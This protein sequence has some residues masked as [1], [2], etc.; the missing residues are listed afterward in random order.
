MRD[1]K[2]RA[3]DEQQ[4][5]MHKVDDIKYCPAGIRVFENVIAEN[6]RRIISSGIGDVINSP[7]VL[8]QYTGLHDVNGKE[9]FDG[10][11]I[12]RTEY[13]PGIY[14]VIWD[15]YRVAWWLKNIKQRELE[16]ADDYCQLLN[17]GW[18]QSRNEVIGNRFENPELM[19]ASG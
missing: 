10:D 1:I 9:I 13:K 7:A 11:I 2:F 15:E 3:W 6:G 12:R 4:K 8:M 19:E 14:T 18:E 17:N 16:Y 5:T